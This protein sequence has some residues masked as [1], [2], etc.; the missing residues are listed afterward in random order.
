ML[1]TWL[2]SACFGKSL[3]VVLIFLRLRRKNHEKSLPPKIHSSGFTLSSTRTRVIIRREPQC[4][5]L[6]LNETALF[7]QCIC[8]LVIDM[9]FEN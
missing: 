2:A 5:I 9:F 3:F 7:A 1:F 4:S 6:N 8:I